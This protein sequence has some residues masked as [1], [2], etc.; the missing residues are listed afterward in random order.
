MRL[1][2]SI[3]RIPDDVMSLDEKKAALAAYQQDGE[4]RQLEYVDKEHKH[5]QTDADGNLFINGV[6]SNPDGWQ[7]KDKAGKSEKISEDL[8]RVAFKDN[9]NDPNT[10]T[11]DKVNYLWAHGKSPEEIARV[12]GP[13][14]EDV[15]GWL[16]PYKKDRY[17]VPTV[18]PQG[19]AQP[20][21][22]AAPQGKRMLYTDDNGKKIPGVLLP[23]GMF[24]PD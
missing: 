5:Y 24:Q 16:G 19:A 12:L 11:Q 21:P 7:T 1:M 13:P 22:A 8:L 9:W 2:E 15:D 14:S 23:D 4:I 10:S 17:S 20:A 6:M 3:S 18:A